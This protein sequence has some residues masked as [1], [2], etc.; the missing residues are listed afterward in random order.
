M[1][2]ATGRKLRRVCDIDQLVVINKAEEMLQ[3][4]RVRTSSCIFC[5]FPPLGGRGGANRILPTFK[6]KKK[7]TIFFLSCHKRHHSPSL[8]AFIIYLVLIIMSVFFYW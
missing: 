2:A 8:I 1:A 6:K 4:H 7:T 3:Q 5:L